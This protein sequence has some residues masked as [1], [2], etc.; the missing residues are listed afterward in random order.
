MIAQALFCHVECNTYT[1]LDLSAVIY[2]LLIITFLHLFWFAPVIFKKY[3]LLIRLLWVLVVGYAVNLFL[4]IVADPFGMHQCP[5]CH[6]GKNFNFS[7]ILRNF[8]GEESFYFFFLVGPILA[9]WIIFLIARKLFKG[10]YQ[11]FKKP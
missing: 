3:S 11:Y 4:F 6:E 10:L 1:D 8:I 5:T 7:L 2:F 9:L